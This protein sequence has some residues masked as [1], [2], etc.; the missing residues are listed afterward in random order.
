MFMNLIIVVTGAT[1]LPF[2]VAEL[3]FYGKTPKIPLLQ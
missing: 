1:G 2:R 3:M